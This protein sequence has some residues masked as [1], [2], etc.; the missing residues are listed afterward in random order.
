MEQKQNKGGKI[1]SV[2]RVLLFIVMI[3]SIIVAVYSFFA[4]ISSARSYLSS[5]G[6]SFK[7][8]FTQVLTY[9]VSQSIPYC[10]YAVLSAGMI[11]LIDFAS[12]RADKKSSVPK[13]VS[14]KAAKETGKIEAAPKETKVPDAAG[15]AVDAASGKENSEEAKSGDSNEAA[16]SGNSKEAE[17]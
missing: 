13:A 5:Y 7:E 8:G 1:Y 17:K 9:V 16:K 4:A 10:V 3:V 15:A 11:L 6:I 2:V 12:G 14:P